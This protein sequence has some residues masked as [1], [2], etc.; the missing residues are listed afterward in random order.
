MAKSVYQILLE[1]EGAKQVQGALNEIG[2]QLGLSGA[3]L[4]A[5]SVGAAKMA[6][7]YEQALAMVATVSDESTGSTEEFSQALRQLQQDTDGAIDIQQAA[8][9]SYNLLSSGIKDQT[10]LMAALELAQKAAIAG[11]SDI[12]TVSKA[13]TSIINSY[14]D[15]LG[16]GL[17]QAEKF[18]KVIDQM[19]VTQNEGEIVI[20]QYASSIG[21]VAASFKLAGLSI[22]E[23]NALISITTVK[24]IPAASAFTN[25][26]QAISNIQQPTAAATQEA[27]RLGIAFDAARLQQVG[28]VGIAK[29]IAGSSNLAADSLAKLFGSVEARN[30]I[31][32]LV[33]SAGELDSAIQKQVQSVGELDSAYSKVS[34]TQLQE[35]NR[36][37][38]LL[39]TSFIDLGNGA[40]VA[41]G[42]VIEMVSRFAATLAQLDPKILQVIGGLTA[43][44]GVTLTLA[45]GTA[46][47]ITSLTTI[48]GAFSTLAGFLGSAVVAMKAYG[49]ATLM[50][51]GGI[52][53][54][55]L[56]LLASQKAFQVLSVAIAGATKS[57]LAM[58]PT[59]G[60]VALAGASVGLA[61][62]TFQAITGE[63]R[64]TR[65][66][67]RDLD[68]ALRDITKTTSEGSLE[69]FFGDEVSQNIEQITAELGPLVGLLNSALELLGL[70]SVSDAKANQT[71]R[72]FHDLADSASAVSLEASKMANQLDKGLTVDPAKLEQMNEVID[73]SI[74]ALKEQK[75]TLQ[76]DIA[77]RDGLIAK[78]EKNKAALN[79]TNKATEESTAV[80][81][82]S[83]QAVADNAQSVEDAAKA[84]DEYANRIRESVSQ[85]EAAAQNQKDAL[86]G[87]Q[88]QIAKESLAIQEQ[89]VADQ[90]A[91][92]ENLKNQSGTSSEERI[93]LEIEI[94][95]KQLAL[96]K[97]RLETQK[98]L[99]DQYN[100][101]LKDSNELKLVELETR[102]ARENL[103]I[104]DTYEERKRLIQEA[105]QIEIDAINQRIEAA[106]DGSGEE[107]ALVLERA[108][109]AR[110]AAVQIRDLDKELADEKLRQIEEI[111]AKEKEAIDQ[112][113]DDIALVMER[114]KAALDQRLQGLQI[115]ND[116]LGIAQDYMS[117][118]EGILNRINGVLNDGNATLGQ[119]NAMLGIAS[120]IISTNV[121]QQINLNNTAE[122]QNAIQQEL[123]MLELTKLQYKMEQLEIEREQLV[124][125]NELKQL[126]I[127]GQREGIQ[128]KLKSSDLSENERTRL[129]QQDE[130]LGRQA[131]IENRKTE[132]QSRGIDNQRRLAEL[133]TMI[134]EA[135][136]NNRKGRTANEAVESGD[137]SNLLN[138]EELKRIAEAEQKAA[139]DRAKEAERSRRRTENSDRQVQSDQQMVSLSQEQLGAM[140]RQTSA[141]Q[142]VARNISNLAQINRDIRDNSRNI[143]GVVQGINRQLTALP[144]NIVRLLPRPAPV[145]STRR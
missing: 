84:Y 9:T 4:T 33:D 111:K 110:D 6:A 115:Y 70:P 35:I 29:D 127:Q 19:V 2:T 92:L 118:T 116:S 145:S 112:R 68:K 13:A 142:D 86:V 130:A 109:V 31:S 81:Q 41:F 39:R 87:S 47:L 108:Q 26:A 50:T 100:Q 123:S 85:I 95:Q 121:G 61:V 94:Q 136:L 62:S 89:A 18:E 125:A 135:I 114:E 101:F 32:V 43:I 78:L 10:D 22:E 133:E 37:L 139:E 137:R 79:E 106:V 97:E 7:D 49:V 54:Q 91:L 117:G 3:A 93:N 131:D 69:D 107:K 71:T 99:E 64:K 103:T 52:S 120:E 51:T 98:E 80:T 14:G 38:N 46:L 119:R 48:V 124:V 105:A 102:A 90:I 28:L 65:E 104:S 88:S 42:P 36:T 25:L 75:P 59:F 11:Q 53:G 73:R 1:I 140:E 16:E 21:A 132:V 40:L 144:G 129:T 15:A 60:L 8:V 134:A 113:L 83:N 143:L 76:A 24:G 55:A 27:T 12:N 141:Q 74:A 23:V 20:D 72:A 66:S 96:N 122:A 126:E 138:N 30:S 82:E 57:L 5:F 67:A 77:L 63:A 56:A 34:T 44:T 128:A 45:G 58:A 17:T